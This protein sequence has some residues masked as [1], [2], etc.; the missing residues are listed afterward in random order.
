MCYDCNLSNI[1]GNIEL[2]AVYVD[3]GRDEDT[4]SNTNYYFSRTIPSYITKHIA[5][6]ELRIV[7]IVEIYPVFSVSFCKA[8]NTLL[9]WL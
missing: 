6:T 2:E 7:T 4:N 1:N 8:L 3:G 5:V 9:S